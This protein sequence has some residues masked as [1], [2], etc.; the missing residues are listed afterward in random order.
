[1]PKARKRRPRRSKPAASFP[2]D[3]HRLAWLMAVQRQRKNGRPIRN[4]RLY[5]YKLGDKYVPAY[6]D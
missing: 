1:M 3:L 4:L 5:Y 6:L 2:D